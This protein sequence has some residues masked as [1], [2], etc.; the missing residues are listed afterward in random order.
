M[1]SSYCATCGKLRGPLELQRKHWSARDCLALVPRRETAEGRPWQELNDLIIHAAVYRNG[2]TSDNC[3]LC[4][5]C[6]RIG[7]RRL[8]LEIDAALDVA[9]GDADKDAELAQIT[10]ALAR[11]Q[12]EVREVETLR[13]AGIP[14]FAWNHTEFLRAVAMLWAYYREPEPAFTARF[15][16]V[17][18]FWDALRDR[19]DAWEKEFK[20]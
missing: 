15:G 1:T 6:L 7:L 2:G 19:L 11:T 4:D 3:H 9:E 10:E 8:K 5:G 14:W 16:Q 12:H 18:D 17:P 13:A 20:A